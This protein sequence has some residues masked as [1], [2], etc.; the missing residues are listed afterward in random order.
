AMWTTRFP[1][2]G[3]EHSQFPLPWATVLWQRGKVAG[4]LASLA[5]RPEKRQLSRIFERQVGLTVRQALPRMRQCQK[6]LLAPKLDV[7]GVS[8]ERRYRHRECRPHPSWR[9]QRGIREPTSPRPRKGRDQGRD[10]TRRC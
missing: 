6:P 4:G 9:F 3:I 8:D 2:P 5:E 7:T 10:R 1:C